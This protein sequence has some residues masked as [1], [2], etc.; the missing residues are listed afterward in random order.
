MQFNSCARKTNLWTLSHFHI[1]V[2]KNF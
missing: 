2:N 1:L